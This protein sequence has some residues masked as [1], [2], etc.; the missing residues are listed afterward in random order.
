MKK[1]RGALH[2][3]ELNGCAESL[4][5][6]ADQHAAHDRESCCHWRAQQ[7]HRRE[8]AKT[9]DCPRQR[10]LGHREL[11]EPCYDGRDVGPS[12]KI[13]PH[14]CSERGDAEREAREPCWSH[15]CRTCGDLDGKLN[16]LTTEAE[17][18]ERAGIGEPQARLC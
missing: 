6:K 12:S 4:A 8:G 10:L 5:N 15:G 16:S 7:L 14:G 18:V 3:V 2:D 17:A 11:D 13:G 1:D 9:R